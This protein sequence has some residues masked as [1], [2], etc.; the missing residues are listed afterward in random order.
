MTL[1]LLPKA[2]SRPP[3]L[4]SERSSRDSTRGLKPARRRVREDRRGS[5]PCKEGLDI[6]LLLLLGGSR[7]GGCRGAVRRGPLPAGEPAGG[8]SAG[9]GVATRFGELVRPAVE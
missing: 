1:P 4:S 5:Q 9:A 6:K 8:L 7:P 3:A 2:A